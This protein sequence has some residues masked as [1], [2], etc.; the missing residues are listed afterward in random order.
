MR[1]QFA[2]EYGLYFYLKENEPY[3]VAFGG[4][5]RRAGGGGRFGPTICPDVC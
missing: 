2:V 1:T 4:F 3:I 5:S